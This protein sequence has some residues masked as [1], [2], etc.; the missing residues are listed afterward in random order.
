MFPKENMHLVTSNSYLESVSRWRYTSFQFIWYDSFF[1]LRTGRF[2][3]QSFTWCGYQREL[4]SCRLLTALLWPGCATHPGKCVF[5]VLDAS[6]LV[7]GQ[8]PTTTQSLGEWTKKISPEQLDWL[9]GSCESNVSANTK[10]VSTTTTT[11]TKK[12]IENYDILNG[13]DENCQ[14]VCTA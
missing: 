11:T 2:C 9:N 4:H 7:P 10:S 13:I 5:F 3:K 6:L 14:I 8:Q 12:V 1:T